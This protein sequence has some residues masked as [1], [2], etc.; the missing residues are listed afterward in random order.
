MKIIITN[1]EMM[2]NIPSVTLFLSLQNADDT[3]SLQMT[4]CSLEVNSTDD[5]DLV[6][7][8]LSK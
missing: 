3:I 2:L 1:D 5:R 4:S 8:D 7:H 6:Q